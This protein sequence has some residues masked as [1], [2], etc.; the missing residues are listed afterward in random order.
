[1]AE[2]PVLSPNNDSVDYYRKRKDEDASLL[3][4]CIAL[5]LKEIWE[6]KQLCRADVARYSGVDEAEIEAF[7]ITGD[8]DMHIVFSIIELL[9]IELT[10][11][12]IKSQSCMCQIRLAEGKQP[13]V[14]FKEGKNEI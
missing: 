5:H 8:A 3:G 10:D 2:K 13:I 1:M 6:A 4:K 11:I 14:F 12:L 9:D 7:E